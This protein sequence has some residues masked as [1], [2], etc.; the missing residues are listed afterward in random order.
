MY[1]CWHNFQRPHSNF[2]Y[3][4][5]NNYHYFCPRVFLPLRKVKLNRTEVLCLEH[6]QRVADYENMTD[7]IHVE[8][9]ESEI[10][11]R[12]FFEGETI[13]KHSTRYT[14]LTLREEQSWGDE[15]QPE[16]CSLNFILKSQR[17][18]KY[19]LHS[20]SRLPK[21]IIVNIYSQQK[22]IFFLFLYSI[23]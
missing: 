22:L 12:W 21:I 13:R 4:P 1:I 18:H 9:H 10:R 14:I 17:S 7:I 16:S 8:K 5:H 20:H 3:L 15:T 11:T 6:K 2:F 19:S 23:S